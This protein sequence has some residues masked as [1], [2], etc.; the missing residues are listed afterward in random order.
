MDELRRYRG[1]LIQMFKLVQGSEKINWHNQ[2]LSIEPMRGKRQQFRREIIKRC[3][4]RH[5]F[6][7]NRIV[8]AW[9][10]L[11]N[12]VVDSAKVDIFKNRLDNHLKSAAS[13]AVIY[14]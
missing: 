5:F 1:D 2:Q 7:T 13:Q 8:N 14:C 3:D 11:P 4:K 10:S 9:N 6:F 12:E